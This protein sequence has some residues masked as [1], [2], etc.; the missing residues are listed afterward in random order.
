MRKISMFLNDIEADKLKQLEEQKGFRSQEMFRSY[1]HE[2]YRREFPP[3]VRKIGDDGGPLDKLSPEDWC[4][5][6]LLGS[7]EGQSCLIMKGASEI[8]IPLDKVKNFES[9]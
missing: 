3:Y 2:L 5:K 8:R 4:K 7:V 6:V 1:I 9:V